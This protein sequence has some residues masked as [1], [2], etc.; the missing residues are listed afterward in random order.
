MLN[1]V[2]QEALKILINLYAL[3][4]WTTTKSDEMLLS[5]FETRIFKHIFR[6]RGLGNGMQVY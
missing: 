1:I 3:E 4:I 5:N 6:M 2:T